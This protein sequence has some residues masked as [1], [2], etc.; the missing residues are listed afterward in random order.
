[1]RARV[2]G[3]TGATQHFWIENGEQVQMSTPHW[4]EIVPEEHGFLLLY[5]DCQTDTW[6]Q[7]L[8]EAKGQARFE[9]GTTD[10]DWEEV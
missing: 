6:H 5:G 2:Y 3:A 10:D 7:S 1:M 9:F 4:V 8:E